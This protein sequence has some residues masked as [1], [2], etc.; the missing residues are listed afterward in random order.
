[1]NQQNGHPAFSQDPSESKDVA[2]PAHDPLMG[3]S[4]RELATDMADADRR[5]TAA[6]DAKIRA[7]LVPGRCAK[8]LSSSD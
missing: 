2:A 4:T 1:M 7:C 8:R 5:A 6:L 3:K